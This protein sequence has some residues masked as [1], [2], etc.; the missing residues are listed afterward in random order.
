VSHEIHGAFFFAKK[1][2]PQESITGSKGRIYEDEGRNLRLI[3]SKR[4]EKREKNDYVRR[5]SHE[6]Y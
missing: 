6:C 5:F 3:G 4:L 2:I 1:N